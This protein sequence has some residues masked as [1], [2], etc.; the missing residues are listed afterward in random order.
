MTTLTRSLTMVALLGALAMLAGEA[1]ASGGRGGHGGGHS[2]SHFSGGHHQVRHSYYHHAPRHA[3]R[4]YV[5]VHS[6]PPIYLLG[7]WTT[8]VEI[9]PGPS[10]LAVA[11]GIG[12]A[13]QV[14]PVQ[15]HPLHGLRIDA[16]T[17]HSAADHGG[18]EPGDVLITANGRPMNCKQDLRLA[19]LSS[20]GHLQ[21]LV[22]KGRTGETVTM[23]VHPELRRLIPVLR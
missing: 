5:S 16:F 22:I 12:P 9:E 4:T 19:V 15:S 8:P 23:V 3:H 20:Q 17:P 13:L 7:V 10:P 18:L 11:G 2:R 1:H 6:P 14:V 21:L